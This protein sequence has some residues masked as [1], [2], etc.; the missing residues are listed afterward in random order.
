MRGRSEVSRLGLGAVFLVVVA[1]VVS[2]CSGSS[3]STATSKPPPTTTAPAGPTQVV[4]NGNGVRVLSGTDTRLSRR[5][6]RG[7]RRV[8]GE[9]K[10]D[11]SPRE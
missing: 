9:C 6:G 1:L 3:K 7:G 5:G 8:E 4:V 2:A 11:R 10:Q